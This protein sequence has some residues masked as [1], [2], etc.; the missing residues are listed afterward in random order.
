MVIAIDATF[1]ICVPWRSDNGGPRDDLWRF[2]QDW[3]Q[4]NFPRCPIV[5]ADVEG[6]LFR[7]AW[8]CN[9]A[10]RLA[11]DWDV[12]VIA[13]ADTIMLDHSSVQ[14]AVNTARGNKVLCYAHEYR[15]MLGPQDTSYLLS[16]GHW[17]RVLD[18]ETTGPHFNTYSGVLAVGTPLWDT[19]GGFDERFEGWGYEDWGFM[20]ACSTFGTLLRAHGECAHLWHPRKHEDEAGQPNYKRNETLFYRYKEAAGEPAMMRSLLADR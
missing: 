8:A 19:V 3:W 18:P 13:D 7:R 9:A 10:V 15:W 14:E 4:K 20:W 12:Y 17:T 6:E 2:T 5:T 11:G 16:H 1:P